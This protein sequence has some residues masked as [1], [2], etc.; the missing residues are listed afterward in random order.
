MTNITPFT[1][2]G[3]YTDIRILVKDVMEKH[4]NVR[5]GILVLFDDEKG[6]LVHH[7]CKASL[8]SF[9]GADLLFKSTQSD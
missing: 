1:K 5:S 9:A 4:P 6:M 7:T 3:S 8:L 2:N